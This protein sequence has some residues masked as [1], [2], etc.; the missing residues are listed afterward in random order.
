M[1]KNEDEWTYKIT[2]LIN[3]SQA[4]GNHKVVFNASDLS[5]GIYIYKLNF[6]SVNGDYN[7]SK[8]M[9]LIK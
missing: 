4:S 7:S 5:S 6:K 3:E 9:S 8:L 1:A 2:E